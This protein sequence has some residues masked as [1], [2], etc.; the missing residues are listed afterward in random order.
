MPVRTALAALLALAAGASAAM[1]QN[2]TET[3]E[4]ATGT[5]PAAEGT[6]DPAPVT[7]VTPVAPGEAP[8]SP[9]EQA[10]AA[11]EAKIREETAALTTLE[12]AL[13][14]CK[15]ATDPRRI[16]AFCSVAIGDQ[17]L[18]GLDRADILIRRG[19]GRHLQGAWAAA[20]VDYERALELFPGN[21]K[22]HLRRGQAL[23]LWNRP[24]RALEDFDYA[25]RLAPGYPEALKSRAITYCRLKR[26]DDAVAD[27]LALIKAGH[28][29]A[30]DAQR[31]F[32]DL[33]YYTGPLTGEFDA[34]SIAAMRVWT[35]QGCP[36]P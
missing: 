28:W 34:A 23:D 21:P 7:P 29:P 24:V 1:A 9:A 18:Q 15:T 14:A 13:E 10:A 32:A 25:L 16:V 2:T 33:G 11:A 12:A 19:E 30:A 20:I 36:R 6:A 27:R 26:V 22:A 8:L 4:P 35:E 31:W 17:G 5:P 3:A